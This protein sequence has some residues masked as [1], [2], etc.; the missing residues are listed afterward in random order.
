MMQLLQQFFIV[1]QNITVSQLFGGLF[2]SLDHHWLIRKKLPSSRGLSASV[3]ILAVS[4]CPNFCGKKSY[5]SGKSLPL[6]LCP[7]FSGK[8]LPQLL[9]LVFPTRHHVIR[10]SI[11]STKQETSST[12][13]MQLLQQC[14]IVVPKLIARP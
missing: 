7:Y 1:V 12:I 8:P 3:P 2:Q 11:G 10:L 9:W 5:F 13:M 14:F 6:S 4:L